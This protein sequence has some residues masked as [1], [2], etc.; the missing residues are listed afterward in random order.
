MNNPIKA[1]L[2]RLIFER[3]CRVSEGPYDPNK[4]IRMNQYRLEQEHRELE[5]GLHKTVNLTEELRKVQHAMPTETTAWSSRETMI[6]TAWILSSKANI[7]E[8]KK[9]VQDAA[10]SEQ[11]E[12]SVV[13]SLQEWIEGLVTDSLAAPVGALML[14][15]MEQVEWLG[16]A[17]RL[18]DLYKK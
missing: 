11:P 5:A 2:E 13:L 4:T 1:Y 12:Q 10:A 6:V 15:S 14:A 9:I 3:S 8:A 18:I 7:T 17:E 16:I